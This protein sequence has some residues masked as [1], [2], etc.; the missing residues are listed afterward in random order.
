MDSLGQ[1]SPGQAAQPVAR[2]ARRRAGCVPLFVLVFLL[3]ILVGVTGL[4]LY[5]LSIANDRPAL[6]TPTP[7]NSDAIVVQ[8]S[9]TYMTRLVAKNINA[10]GLPGTISN[11]QVTM[12]HNG[13]IVVN[14]DDQMNVLGVTV[15]AHFTLYLQP[16]IR[17]CQLQ[18]HV[19]RADMGTIPVTGFVAPFEDQINQQLE[20]KSSALPDGFVYCATGVRTE[21]Q[22][23]FISYSATPT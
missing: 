23:M 19:L 2:V 21:S 12:S 4:L 3:G 13:P 11:V 9:S 17:S 14:G 16:V 8:V 7:G 22:G 1:M 5:A 18:V 20:V 6:A 10:S 15:P